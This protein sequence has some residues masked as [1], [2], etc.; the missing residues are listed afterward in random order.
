MVV[1][2]NHSNIMDGKRRKSINQFYQKQKAKFQN[3][4]KDNCYSKRMYRLDVRNKNRI[5][6]Y[7]NK[8]IHQVISI[9]KQEG[10]YKIVIGYNK[11]IKDLLLFNSFQ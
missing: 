9:A 7:F 3:K 6:D 10:I 2:N 8:A 11:G 5:K 4:S 1:G